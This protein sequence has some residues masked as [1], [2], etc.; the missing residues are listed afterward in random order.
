M[1]EPFNNF[2]TRVVQNQVRHVYWGGTITADGV[3][4]SFGA[5]NIA[6][7]SGRI[8]NE[9]SGSAMEIGTAYSSQLDIGLYIDD[10]GVPRDKIYGATIAISCTMSANGMQGNCPMGVF[11]V[12]EAKQ[13]GAVCSIVAYDNMIKFDVEYPMRDGLL[14]PFGWAAII[15]AECGVTLGT[16]EA[17]FKAMPNGS[18]NY[19]LSWNDSLD[20]YRTV[21]GMLAAVV[22]CSAHMNRAGQLVFM[23][24]KNKQ[25][26]AT[27][28]ANDRFTSGI[29]QTVTRPASI[30][31][32]NI[33]TGALTKVGDGAIYFDL[34][35]NGFLQRE[36]HEKTYDGTWGSSV[37]VSAMLENILYSCYD[38]NVTPVDAEIPLD[39][40]LDL[41]DIVTLTGGQANNTKV[42]ITSL[43]HS[44]GG[45]TELKCAGANTAE[46]VKDATRGSEGKSEDFMWISAAS[47]EEDIDIPTTTET[48]GDQ[49]SK[50][51]FR[52]TVS[53]WDSLLHGGG[54]I[55]LAEFTRNFTADFTL[56]VCG[57]TV[58]YETSVDTEVSFKIIIDRWQYDLG[59]WHQIPV[60]NWSCNEH[61]LKGK[62]TSSLVIPFGILDRRVSNKYH[63]TAN[64]SGIDVIQS[65]RIL[66]RAE[67]E[68]LINGG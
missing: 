9:I 54:W 23:P 27:V 33:E 32:T 16:T 6:A 44:I 49:L 36:G 26:V 67:I 61:A 38:L 47:N 39:P 31:V 14:L 12:V 55:T 2:Y 1:Y 18:T 40:S 53:T 68:S 25:S 13:T 11:N 43:I 19:M 60:G 17:Q 51:W 59:E 3:D 58:D 65:L 45:S 66:T 21:I 28:K 8:I 15:C 35:T 42:I 56:G 64:A 50:T 30:Y 24:L 4:Y 10:I 57:L 52:L 41:F 22:G 29:A 37:T 63:F 34:K 5:D 48:W 46:D 62:H 7:G 20:T